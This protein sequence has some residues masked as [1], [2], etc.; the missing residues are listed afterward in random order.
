MKGDPSS[1]IDTNFRPPAKSI[2][3]LSA[4]ADLY[5]TA[6]QSGRRP[7]QAIMEKYNVDRESAKSWPQLC[8]D[9]GLLPPRDQ[10]QFVTDPD[11]TTG[12]GSRL[13]S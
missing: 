6:L 4:I 5:V 9:A 11:D 2:P 1:G 3:D 8:R 12:L 10:P 7:I 13:I